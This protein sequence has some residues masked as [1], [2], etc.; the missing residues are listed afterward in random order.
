M[1]LARSRIRGSL[2]GGA[3]G[4]ALGAAVARQSLE[5]MRQHSGPARL[6]QPEP[7]PGAVTDETQLMLFTAEGLVMAGRD[8]T[9]AGRSG[10]V[11]SVHRA[12][13]RWLKT[14]GEHS[15]HPTFERTSE[16]WLL[17]RPELHSRCA[18]DATF[19]VA[20]RGRRMGRVE[21][22]L[23]S[24]KGGRGLAR[25]AVVGLARSIDDPFAAAREI[26]GLTH[27]HPS[28]CLTA[29]YLAL[30]V[31]E[32]AAGT[33]LP[34]ACADALEELCRYPDCEACRAVIEHALML[35][36]RGCVEPSDWSPHGP[37]RSAAELLAV[38]LTYALVAPDFE[39]ALRRAADRDGH[40]STAA[41]LV[42][43]L[44]GAAFGDEAIHPR[45]LAQL[46]LRPAIERTAEELCNAG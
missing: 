9:L 17:P 13:L 16:G 3:V 20:L 10:A 27:G 6:R 33:P 39:T 36:E 31:R 26:A 21:Q 15:G 11:R 41:A 42:G 5:A 34:A 7:V 8:P 14:Q 2:L 4:D 40:S 22:P 1:A 29:G 18:P 46:E 35:D 23:N 24:S 43:S 45:L 32:V 44:L 30:L 12:Y 25:M 38:A 37:A 19:L 28:A